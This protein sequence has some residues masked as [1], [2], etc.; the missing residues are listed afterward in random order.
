[1][2][3]TLPEALA[4]AAA[5]EEG[6]VYLEEGGEER[7]RPYRYLLARA[8]A[9]GGAL[10]AAGLERGDRVAL[11]VPEPEGFLEAF[12]GTS[13]AGLVPVPLYPPMNVGQLD[14]WVRHATH[15]VG[16]ARAKAILTTAQVRRVLGGV[17]AACPAVR[18]VLCLEDLAGAPLAAVEPVR[19]GDTAFI[20]FTSGSTSHPKGVVLT[21]AN[22]DANIQAL[23]GPQGI[24]IGPRDVGVSWLP[25]YHDMGLI[26]MAMATMYYERR[27]VVMSPLLFLKRPAEWLRAIARHRATISFAPNFAY[28]LCARRVRD[29]EVARLDLSSWRVAGCGAEPIQAETLR[30]FA[31]KVAPAGF[32]EEA[33]LP[34]YGM[35]EHTLAITFPASARRLVTDGGFV[36]CGRPFPGHDLRIVDERDRQ[37]TERH[38]GEIV[39]RGPSVMKEYDGEPELTGEALR[40]GWLHTGD[41]GYLAAGE[42]FV[43]GRKKDLIIVNGRNHYPQDLEWAAGEVPGVRRGNVVAFGAGAFGGREKVVIVVESKTAAVPAGLAEAVRRHVQET[44]GLHVDDVVVAPPGTIPKTSSG[45]LQRARTKARYEQGDLLRRPIRRE[46]VLL[47][48][49]ARSQWGYLKAFLSRVVRP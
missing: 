40:G 25:L 11:V 35:A 18:A 41:L 21:H 44:S 33:F 2:S 28:G 7:F 45:K 19:P 36:G 23:G 16:A 9:V 42:L 8:L 47:S 30:A 37:V 43:C 17:Q 14:G 39:L 15:I 49:L 31:A 38:V 34:C 12:F 24:A 10:R 20:Q 4:A 46:L 6:F 26:G 32:R 48:E 3:R 27:T 13:C 29:E 22:L 5:T 1:M